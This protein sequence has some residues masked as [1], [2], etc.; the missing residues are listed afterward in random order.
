MNTRAPAHPSPPPELAVVIVNF[1][2]WAHLERCLESIEAAPPRLTLEIVVVD[3]DSSDGSPDRVAEQFPSVRLVRLAANR[4][5][6]AGCNAGIRASNAAL[7]LLLNPDTVVPA[8]ALDAL[9]DRLR[10]SP[11]AAVAGPRLVDDDGVPELS[12]GRMISPTV[13]ARQKVLVS[14]LT[15]RVGWAVRYVNRLT[16]TEHHPD[17]VSGAC[18]LVR[19]EVAEAVG[20]LDERFFLYTEDVDFCAAVRRT[21]ARVLFTPVAQMV[22]LRG[23]SR[24]L[25][26]SASARAYRTSQVAFYE[27]HLPRWAPWLRLYLRLTGKGPR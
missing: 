18:L 1:N 14:L 4:G 20:L 13:E 6:A 16:S 2:V 26:S 11:E 21:G 8:G 3:N 19:R 12:F 9:C 15:H 10:G 27:K 5:F 22:H 25:A 23:R 17:W 24:A 7:I